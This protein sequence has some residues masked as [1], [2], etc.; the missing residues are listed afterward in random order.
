[1]CF[2]FTSLTG[3][4]DAKE[5]LILKHLLQTPYFRIVVVDDTETVELC[6]ALKVNIEKK[7]TN[8]ESFSS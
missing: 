1:M 4:T 3:C 5:G 6:G 2:H 8:S 7:N